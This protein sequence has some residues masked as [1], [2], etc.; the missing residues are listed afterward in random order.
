MRS[1]KALV[2]GK[3]QG[4]WYRDSTRRRAIDLGITGYAK[5][6]ANG[7]V[8]VVATGQPEA[9]SQLIQWLNQGPPNA[10]VSSVTVEDIDPVSIEGFRTC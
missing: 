1:V 5:N 9:V 7:Q 6:L 2:S 4:V 10:V 3:V 8:E